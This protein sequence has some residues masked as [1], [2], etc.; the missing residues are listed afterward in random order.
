MHSPEHKSD[1]PGQTAPRVVANIKQADRRFKDPLE[2]N[3]FTDPPRGYNELLDEN[4]KNQRVGSCKHFW[5]TQTDQSVLPRQERGLKDAKYRISCFCQLCR[6]HVDVT[7]TLFENSC[8]SEG[9]PLHHFA[10]FAKL[11]ELEEWYEG[12]CTMCAAVLN[13]EYREPR[14]TT[15]DIA[16][17]TDTAR[18][19][20]R[21]RI[22][23]EKDPDRPDLKV[24]Q[25]VMVLDALATYIC[26]S[27]QPKETHREIPRL[28]R[29]FL[30]SF[31]EDCEPLLRKLQF[32]QTEASW[33]LPQPP[34]EDPWSAD[35]R[36]YLQDV[37]EELWA[38]MRRHMESGQQNRLKAYH[39][40]PPPFDSD[41]KLLL[42]TI[43]YDK[44]HYVKRATFIPVD[45]ELLHAGLGSLGDFTDELLIYAFE[46]QI[47][48]DPVGTPYYY[49]CLAKLAD[50]RKSETLEIKVMMLASEGYFGREDVTKAYKYFSL[51]AWNASNYTDEYIRNTFE[52]RLGSVQQW[53]ETE[54]RQMLRIIAMSRGSKSLEGSA[55]NDKL[56]NAAEALNWLSD[57][58]DNSDAAA[59]DIIQA[60]AFA[61]L[62]ADNQ[63]KVL[64]AMTLIANDRN[65]DALRHWIAAYGD[66]DASGA[67]KDDELTRAYSHYNI[68]DRSSIVDMD[69]LQTMLSMKLQDPDASVT[70]K[71][72]SQR[73]FEIIRASSSTLSAAPAV[74][75]ID[76]NS[77]VGLQNLGNTCYLNCVLQYFYA[78]K[79]FREIV[80]NLDHHKLPLRNY[81]GREEFG[82]VGGL[83][84]TRPY[85]KWAQSFL[86]E[87]A[88]LFDGMYTSSAAATPNPALAKDFLVK[89][90]WLLVDP[91]AAGPSP[92]SPDSD[93]GVSD[94]TLVGDAP[95]ATSDADIPMIDVAKDEKLAGMSEDDLKRMKEFHD[96]VKSGN[97]QAASE[98]LARQQDVHEI[99]ANLINKAVCAMKPTGSDWN[100][101]ERD[102]I[103]RLFYSSF[104]LNS[105]KGNPKKLVVDHTVTVHLYARPDGIPEALEAAF[106]LNH[107]NS[108]YQTFAR[109]APILQISFLNQE[110][111][112]NVERI[113]THPFKVP[114]QIN[115]T[116]YMDQPPKELLNLR[117]QYWDTHRQMRER[118]DALA[119][120]HAPLRDAAGKLVDVDGSELL[121]A[122]SQFL[123]SVQEELG[124]EFDELDD[125]AS[126]LQVVSGQCRSSIQTLKKEIRQ[127][128]SDLQK[129]SAALNDKQ[130]MIKFTSEEKVG[131]FDYTLFAV[132]V[133]RSMNGDPGHGH[134]YIYLHDFAN[135]YWRCYNDS[136]VT[137]ENG[138]MN[139]W[140]HGSTKQ[141]TGR[142]NLV[143]YVKTSEKDKLTQPLY[144]KKREPGD[145]TPPC[146][147]INIAP[148]AADEDMHDSA[149]EE[150]PPKT[151]IS[152]SKTVAKLATALAM[153]GQQIASYKSLKE[154]EDV[155]HQLAM[156]LYNADLEAQDVTKKEAE[157]AQARER[158][159]EVAKASIVTFHEPTTDLDPDFIM[160]GGSVSAT[161]TDGAS[162]DRGRTTYSGVGIT[163]T[164]VSPSP[165]RG[166]SSVSGEKNVE[167]EDGYNAS[168]ATSDEPKVL[169]NV[170]WDE[171]L[172]TSI[173]GQTSQGDSSQHDDD[174][175]SEEAEV[176][177]DML[178]REP[179]ERGTDS[180][181]T[182][183]VTTAPSVTVPGTAR[184]FT[185]GSLK[186]IALIL[187]NP[188]L[189]GNYS[190]VEPL[191]PTIEEVASG[192]EIPPDPDATPASEDTSDPEETSDAELPSGCDT[193]GHAQEETAVG[194]GQE[195][196]VEEEGEEGE[197][198][199]KEDE[200]YGPSHKFW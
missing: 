64:E 27:L 126:A 134:Y 91:M 62:D 111:I 38:T 120:L 184:R 98:Q 198:E 114:Q 1:I 36:Q 133:H 14:L 186:R 125:V 45:E 175:D 123:K 129:A 188:S 171:D 79:T 102:D 48:H 152:P 160:P 106:E 197:E 137:V 20:E 43:E 189:K 31:G 32:V 96:K 51:D 168:V 115:L 17:L 66:G 145:P 19:Q 136:S 34:P 157:E 130:K 6:W 87:L 180:S 40:R 24:T 135:Q 59:D 70:D 165:D 86:A 53:Q 49:D 112:D 162:D 29:R 194:V 127:I 2:R 68:Q 42:S 74:T 122:S 172:P 57:G 193:A 81:P 139:E 44:S 83:Q 169:K 195:T 151:E 110:V 158:A 117:K 148:A 52:A 199:E 109:P 13:I 182:P 140:I 119:R 159:L 196:A 155:D 55:A 21:L 132:F 185:C 101:A 173:D 143:V 75:P 26:D 150:D 93:G 131:E 177:D 84:V 100:G 105:L 108:E 103:T 73:Y 41:I 166:L 163:A 176:P 16:L 97:L 47:K 63:E 113:I 99:A 124:S 92:S 167:A 15:E 50:K 104:H 138:D 156:D 9:E 25:P 128:G 89:L 179:I 12:R 82:Q 121:N 144:R 161:V 147:A 192:S 95:T 116:R 164:E 78:V 191:M 35:L 11:D 80:T 178:F 5:T 107:V 39:E 72:N 153:A 141:G 181:T 118:E 90:E 10:E 154:Q 18:L 187:P 190:F 174:D 146:A 22:A 69:V 58:A 54:M 28:N 67:F 142:P 61:K 30:L 46:Q 3:P 77:P 37:Q 170:W 33:Q 60:L 56:R 65:S 183:P 94:T 149:T 23:R 8:P 7:I 88:K 4:R 200:E 71:E 76:H 85:V